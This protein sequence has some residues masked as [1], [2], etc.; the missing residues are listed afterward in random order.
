MNDS[1]KSQMDDLVKAM[2]LVQIAF[3]ISQMVKQLFHLLFRTILA[4]DA[5]CIS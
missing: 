5:I 4:S 2:L 1:R 3:S